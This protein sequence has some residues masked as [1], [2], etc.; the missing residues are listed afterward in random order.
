MRTLRAENEDLK[1]KFEGYTTMI[2]MA[3][4]EIASLKDTISSL[5]TNPPTSSPSPASNLPLRS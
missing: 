4:D 1:A 5:K 2:T 3:S